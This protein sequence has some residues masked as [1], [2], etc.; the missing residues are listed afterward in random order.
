MNNIKVGRYTNPVNIGWQGW[1]EPEDRSW[2]AFIDLDGRPKFYLHRD[3][4]GGVIEDFD[5]DGRCA[6]EGTEPDPPRE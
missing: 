4:K 3:E 6:E 5:D 1:I 2:I